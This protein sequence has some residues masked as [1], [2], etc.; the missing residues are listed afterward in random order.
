M[1]IDKA[2]MFLQQADPM[3]AKLIKQYDLPNLNPNKNYF[4]SLV[5][6]IIYQQLSGSAANAIYERFK[7]LLGYHS[8]SQS[9]KI[10]EM[11]F[12]ELQK[13]GLSKQKIIY[14]KELSK[15]WNRIQRKFSNIQMMTN[16]EIS[17]ILLEVKG[18]GQW[19]VDMFLIFTLCREDVFPSGDLAIKKGFA[20]IRNMNTLP[21]E[22][23]MVEKSEIWK[24]YRTVASLYL[25]KITDGEFE[26]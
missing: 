26:W 14:L 2:I 5:R 19:T 23:Y 16:H 22:K 11:P 21:T 20:T 18:I 15:Q 25:W 7:N 4:E 8:F 17:K 24:P 12:E 1:N 10:L 3:M 9:E 13:V 6:S